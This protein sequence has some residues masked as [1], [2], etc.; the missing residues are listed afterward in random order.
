M[1]RNAIVAT[2]LVLV[3]HVI[4]FAHGDAHS[5]LGVD[6]EMWQWT[7]VY[8]VIT[9]LPIL[10]V[11]LYWTRWQ[12]QGALLLAVSMLGSLLFGIYHHFV[13]VSPDHVSHLPPGDAQGLFVATAILL[14]VSEAAGT[15]FGFWS[16]R[17]AGSKVA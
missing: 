16:W 6:L 4:A 7:Y 17:R 5:R 3:H 15:A 11:G 14:A 13:A 8:V 10:A 9:L 12:R 1:T 2:V